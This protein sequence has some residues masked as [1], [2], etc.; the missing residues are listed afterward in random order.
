MGKRF[1]SLDIL[2][3]LAIILMLVLHVF[4]AV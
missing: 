1:V 4:Y 3:G 2:R